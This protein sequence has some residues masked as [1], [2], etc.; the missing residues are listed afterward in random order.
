MILFNCKFK[1]TDGE[2]LAGNQLA[3]KGDGVSTGFQCLDVQRTHK[4]GGIIHKLAE[5]KGIEVTTFAEGTSGL[6]SLTGGI[7]N[8]YIHDADEA[9]TG[10]FAL[11]RK[12][13]V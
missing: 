7:G 3:L 4:A 2:A 9:A 11:D 12:S 5:H 6:H 8:G 10:E 1:L 13:V